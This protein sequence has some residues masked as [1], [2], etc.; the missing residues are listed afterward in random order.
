MR[1][2]PWLLTVFLALA[3]D[4]HA[5]QYSGEIEVIHPEKGRRFI[6]PEWRYINANPLGDEMNPVRVFK[7]DDMRAYLARLTCPEGGAPVYSPIPSHV[8]SPYGNP[9]SAWIVTCVNTAIRVYI[10]VG[11]HGYIEKRPLPGF[12]IRD[13]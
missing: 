1:F 8:R 7:T 5:Q 9:L 12:K 13:P 4:A 6:V 2:M 10:D 11:H 3:L